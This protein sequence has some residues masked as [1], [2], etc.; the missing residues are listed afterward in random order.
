V[1]REAWSQD[2]LLR[3]QAIALGLAIDSSTL[4]LYSS[5]LNSYLT[6]VRLHNHPVEP[7]ADT[8]SLYTVFMSHHIRPSSVT[9]YLSGICQQLKLYFP[10][11]CS[12]HNSSL[13]DRT[14]KGC[15]RLKETPIKRKR[16]LTFSDFKKVITDLSQSQKLDDL[17][18]MAMLLTGFFALMQL[19]ELCFP[20]DVKLRNWKKISKCSS[21]IISDDQYEFHL[22]AHKADCFFEGNRIIV[23]KQQYCDIN[24]L[25]VFHNYLAMHDSQFPLASPLWLTSQG[26]VATQDFFITQLHYYFNHDVTGQ[27]MRAGGATSLAENGVPPSLIQ[28]IRQWSS[29]AFLI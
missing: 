25:S 1:S 23:K 10:N 26:T 28:L 27:S 22:P 9:S 3:E 6:F 24:P 20:N 12:A 18:F 19:G 17:L 16:A 14:I 21:V 8:L 11:I 2:K 7:S 29:D 4:N 5:A 13:V 15:M